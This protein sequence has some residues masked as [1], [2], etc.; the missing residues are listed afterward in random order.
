MADLAARFPGALRQLDRFPLDVIEGR[1]TSLEAAAAGTAP[2]PPW[3][4]WEVAYHG[5][6]RATLRVKRA[7]GLAGPDDDPMRLAVQAWGLAGQTSGEPG[8]PGEPPEP[9]T[10]AHLDVIRWPSGGRLNTQVLVDVAQE[11][12]ATVD[13]LRRVLF[14]P[15][16][17]GDG[18]GGG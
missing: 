18:G 2:A 1:L 12:G 9:F 4:A 11:V 17:A 15:I 16:S 6:L 13:E 14:G 7:L 3:A 8:E 10:R 5:R